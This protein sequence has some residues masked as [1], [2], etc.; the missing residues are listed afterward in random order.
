MRDLARVRL[1]L[2]RAQVDG[3]HEDDDAPA[4]V[5]A[6]ARGLAAEGAAHLD[7]AVGP[8]AAARGALHAELV[9]AVQVELEALTMLRLSY[10]GSL[11]VLPE[12][13][14]GLAALTTLDLSGCDSLHALPE[15]ICRLAVLPMLDLRGCEN[16]T[17]LPEAIDGL[18]ALAMLDLRGCE[19]LTALPEAICRLAVL[20]MLDTGFRDKLA[21]Q[22]GA[23]GK[24]AAL[25]NLD[26]VSLAQLEGH[27]HTDELIAAVRAA[28]GWLPYVNAPRTELL[29][30]RQRLPALR[31]RGRAAPSSSL[32]V[33]ER[34]FLE[35]PDDVFSHVL[36]F[37]RSDRDR[38]VVRADRDFDPESY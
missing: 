27:Q 9:R 12:A 8:D 21:A 3:L 5:E 26:L 2:E 31:D 22:P 24:F 10:C 28:G 17:A 4:V 25:T 36:T 6:E 14:G 38:H 7:A 11:T 23:I 18:A 19:S 35:T 37:W 16:L 34:L 1:V 30:L 32:R 33:Y 15:A 29:A 20:P 13:I